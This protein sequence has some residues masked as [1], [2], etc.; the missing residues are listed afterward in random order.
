MY[1]F[2][3][4]R[5][6]PINVYSY[7]HTLLPLPQGGILRGNNALAGRGGGG[8]ITVEPLHGGGRCTN[9]LDFNSI[10]LA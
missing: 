6:R 8:F 1:T 4:H 7:I 2:T 5:S 10:V 3:D 9:I